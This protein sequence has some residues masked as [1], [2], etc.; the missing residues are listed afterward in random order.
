MVRAPGQR[1]LGGGFDSY[2]KLCNLFSSSF[3]RC[4]ATII[5]QGIELLEK[6]RLGKIRAPDGIWTHDPLWSSRMLS[7]LSYQ[8]LCGEQRSNCGSS[9]EPHRAVTQPTYLAHMDSMY[10]IFPSLRFS[11]NSRWC[12]SFPI[13]YR[14]VAQH[15][16]MGFSICWFSESS[17]HCLIVIRLLSNSEAMVYLF[18]SK[19]HSQDTVSR[20]KTKFNEQKKRLDFRLCFNIVRILMSEK[21]ENRSFR[22]RIFKLLA[23]PSA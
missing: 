23:V 14:I 11:W 21:R 12:C 20:G 13:I 17:D 5:L 22:K 15:L 6:R 19:L 8:R 3:T 2:Q 10:R 7:S 16:S 1:Y 9:L 18:A 4:K